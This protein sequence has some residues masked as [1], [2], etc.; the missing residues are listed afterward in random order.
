MIRVLKP[1][2]RALTWTRSHLTAKRVTTVGV[3]SAA[4]IIAVT[5]FAFRDASRSMER[6]ADVTASRLAAA[7]ERDIARNVELLDVELRTAAAALQSA[8]DPNPAIL[9]HFPRDRYISFIEMVNVKGDVIA[10]SPPAR[11]RENWASRDYFREATK[12]PSDLPFIGQVFGG[13]GDNPAISVSRRISDADGTFAGVVV[14]GLKLD[15]F[16][17]LLKALDLG[18]NTVATVVQSDGIVLARLPYDRSE[19]GR[20]IDSSEP[21]HTFVRSGVSTITA[22]DSIGRVQRHFAFRRVGNLPLVVGI[23][24]VTDELYADGLPLIWLILL[25]FGT[26]LMVIASLSVIHSIERRKRKAAELKNGEKTPFSNNA[27][28]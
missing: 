14:I 11:S 21:Y 16:H 9:D 17:D 26:L 2:V 25:G 5:V 15:Y 3:W 12:A 4:L 27:E 23:G 28:P 22:V 6:Q 7:V 24:I 20:V 19:V 1:V 8:A 13:N 18:P 10:A